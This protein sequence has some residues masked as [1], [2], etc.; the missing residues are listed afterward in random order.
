[1]SGR[2]P[3]PARR[4]TYSPA[5]ISLTM[6]SDRSGKR[7]GSAARMRRGIGQ[8]AR[9]RLGGKRHRRCPRPRLDAVPAFGR[10][11]DPAEA[12][13]ARS[14][15]NRAVASL[16]AIMK[17]S[18]S[19]RARS[20][21]CGRSSTT[22]RRAPPAAPRSSPGAGRRARGAAR[23]AGCAAR[24]GG[25]AVPPARRR[26]RPPAAPGPALQPGRDVS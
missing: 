18:I 21:S 23:A 8:G 14:C 10:A 4:T 17:S 26:R 2:L 22:V 16:A 3:C 24:P 6:A 20:F 11:H 7:S 12:G 19:S 13:D 15:R 9:V 25:A 5:P 1:M